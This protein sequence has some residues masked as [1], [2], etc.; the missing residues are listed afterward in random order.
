MVS[1][2]VSALIERKV[3]MKKLSKWRFIALILALLLLLQLPEG[4]KQIFR[5]GYIAEIEL[6]GFIADDPAR[7][8]VLDAIVDN[9]EIQAVI[10]NIN[11]PGGTFVG[12]ER[13][14]QKFLQISQVKPVVAVLGD[15]AT[16]AAYMAALGSDYIV[17]SNGSLTGSVGVLLQ[18]FDL[19]ELA[20][21]IGISPLII[22]SDKYKA[23]PHPAEKSDADTKAYLQDLIDQSQEVF[24]A[25]VAE[26][27]TKLND[28]QLAEISSGKVF[29]G[30]KAKE[31]NLIDALGDS[32]TAL[33]WLQQNNVLVTQI[34][35]LS[36]EP[37][38]NK[39]KKLLNLNFISKMSGMMQL[40]A[41]F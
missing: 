12:G 10:V 30:K 25:I 6:A 4:E 19:T 9:D 14:Y 23:A 36:L 40:L 11:S 18:S 37:P 21:K 32:D 2:A 15:Q 16:S 33:S 34:K 24:L 5:E 7:N 28:Q 20:Q 29:I 27:R 22:K 8:K 41:V 26:R 13:L 1:K 38:Q 39:I 17:A 31:L 35:Q 3:F